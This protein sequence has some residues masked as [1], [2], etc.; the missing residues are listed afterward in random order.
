MAAANMRN[1]VPTC[2][3]CNQDYKL[4]KDILADGSAFYPYATIPEVKVEVDC[5]AYP[6]MDHLADTGRWA[7]TLKLATPD[8]AVSP[9][10]NAWERVYSIKE[11][12]ENEVNE[13]F[14]DWMIELSDDYPQELGTED[15]RRLIASACVKATE[16]SRRRMQPNQI[17]RAA[18]YHFM[19]C[20]AERSF[21]ESF[22]QLLNRRLAY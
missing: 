19:L 10:L 1:L 3:T 5:R 20:K 21:V 16:Q 7:V 12:L 22:R 9:K 4:A 8:P 13:S 11:R 17:V 18:F 15:F 14:E 6:E 2:G